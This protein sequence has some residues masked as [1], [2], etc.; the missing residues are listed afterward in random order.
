MV[1][2]AYRLKKQGNRRQPRQLLSQSW[3]NQFFHTVFWFLLLD[4]MQVSQETGKMVWYSHF[5]KSLTQ[6]VMMHTVKGF[7]V[8]NVTGVDVFLEFPQFSSVAQSRMA[9]CDPMNR[10]T[11]GLPVHHRSWILNWWCH[12][13]ISYSVIP[14]SSCPQSLPASKSFQMTQLFTSG[15]QSIGV[16][17]S[18]SVLPMNTQDWSPL[19][20][21]GWI[22]CSPRDSQESSPTP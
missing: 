7:D 9:P 4:P 1:C 15:S 3:T 5:F 10:S 14:F 12:P 20:W 19:G 13:V 17:A 6:F 21:T 2:S 11:S 8:V 22:P 18:T 16:S